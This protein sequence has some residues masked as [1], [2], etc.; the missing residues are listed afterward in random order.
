MN[1][2]RLT[3][4]LPA[5]AY[6]TYQVAAP[7]STHY[8][9]ATCQEFDCQAMIRGWKT[10]VDTS[11]ELGQRQ[12]HYIRTESRRKFREERNMADQR[13]V[14]F[15]FEPGQICFAS[16]QVRTERPE[17]YLVRDGDWRGNP[18]G[19]TPRRHANA[20][21]WLEDFSEHQGRLAEEIERG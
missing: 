18:R 20:Q 10:V 1:Q 14:M 11:T 16:H 13:V 3:P 4:A 5:H 2:N 7:I 12:A 8:R 21:D 9:P 6:K 19:T 17:V 15:C